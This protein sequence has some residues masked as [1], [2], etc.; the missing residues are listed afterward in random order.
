MYVLPFGDGT[1]QTVPMC[2]RFA[3]DDQVNELL[4][5]F[6]EEHG[7]RALRDWRASF[8]IAPTQQ[9][10]VLR[11]HSGQREVLPVRWGMVSPGSPTFGGG[12]PVFNARIETVSTNGLFKRPFAESR[13]I[14]FASGYYE[15]QLRDDGKQPFYI[16]QPGEQIAMAGVTRAWRDPERSDDDPDRWRHSMSIITRDAHVAPGDI[17]DRMPACLTPDGY[18]EWLGGDL[19]VDELLRTLDDE[20]LRV[21]HELE[22]YEVSR[23]VNST[24]NDG[25]QLV[26][27]LA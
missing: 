24:K 1:R 10:P 7:A 14:V 2:G 13:C 6:V 12:K 21:A 23:E 20:S 27:P 3:M 26:T 4:E 9:V 17:H 8:N 5:S 16:H 11:E 25:P 15:W 22:Y 18:A 19:P